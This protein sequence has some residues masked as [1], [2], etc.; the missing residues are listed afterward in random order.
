MDSS[1]PSMSIVQRFTDLDP[2][3]F[4]DEVNKL[5]SA[6]RHVVDTV[7]EQVAEGALTPV[8]ALGIIGCTTSQLYGYNAFHGSASASDLLSAIGPDR[9]LARR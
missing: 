3:E 1:S 8:Q 4:R 9:L 7:I 2:V 5:W 6:G